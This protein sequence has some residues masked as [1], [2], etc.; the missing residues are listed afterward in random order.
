MIGPYFTNPQYFSTGA[1]R[2]RGSYILQ[3]GD[4]KFWVW[5]GCKSRAHTVAG[6]FSA[7]NKFAERVTSGKP[8]I[9]EVIA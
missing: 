1:L 8:V 5:H 6:A 7:A 9:V 2:S 3:D 4:E